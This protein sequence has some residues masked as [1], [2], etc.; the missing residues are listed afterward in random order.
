MSQYKMVEDYLD[1]CNAMRYDRKTSYWQGLMYSAKFV[2]NSD[3]PWSCSAY[4][5]IKQKLEELQEGKIKLKI[6][7]DYGQEGLILP[8]SDDSF[9][10]MVIYPNG[11]IR[12][13][14]DS[15]A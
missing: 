14:T 8:W 3:G 4:E 6:G 11:L 13:Y 10:E 5:A 15:A 2:N 9:C 7:E 1:H 12:L